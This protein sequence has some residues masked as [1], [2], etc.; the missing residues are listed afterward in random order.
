MNDRSVQISAMS[1]S[2]IV[3]ALA[4]VAPASA[5]NLAV[6][7]STVLPWCTRPA[8]RTPIIRCNLEESGENK[9]LVKADDVIEGETRALTADEVEQVGNLVEDDEWLG[10]TMEVRPRLPYDSRPLA[11]SAPGVVSTWE[12]SVHMSTHN[13]T[14]ASDSSF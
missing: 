2:A 3:L 14:A 13:A 8:V 1:S 7:S 11:R 4:L 6:R 9:A 10:L 5:F 12:W